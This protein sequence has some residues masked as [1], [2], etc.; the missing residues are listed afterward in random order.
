MNIIRNIYITTLLIL[1]SCLSV[2]EPSTAAPADKLH[3]ILILHS[4]HKGLGWTDGITEGIETTLRKSGLDYELFYEFLDS[5]RIAD[6][7]HSANL[8][9]T[10]RHKYAGRRFAAII[11]SDDFAFNFILRYREELFPG[12]PVVFCGVNFFEDGML[13]GHP[14]ITG[15][16]ESFSL[17]GTID[18]AL[19]INP[20]IRKIVAIDDNTITGLANRKLLNALIPQ[21]KNRLQF[22]FIGWQTM[23]EIQK[24]C[25]HLPDEAIVLLLSFTQDSAGEIFS[26][27]RSADLITPHCSVPVF[28]FWDFH[29]HHGVIGG[30]LTTGLSQGEKAAELALRILRGEAASDIPVVKESP[31]KYIFDYTVM[32]KFAID[33]DRLPADSMVINK[34][35]SLY[36]QYKVFFWQIFGAFIFLITVICLIS[37]NLIRRRRA[38]KALRRSEE[39]LRTIFQAAKTVA[40]VITDARLPEPT[41]IEFS[42]GAETIFG[43]SRGEVIGRPVTILHQAEDVATFPQGHKQMVE[44]RQ[45]L[46][47]QATLVRKNGE[48]F[49]AL[50]SSHPLFDEH[51]IMRAA[52]GV[53]IDITEQKKTEAALRESIERFRELSELLPETIFEIDFTGKILFLNNSGMEQFSFTAE[54]MAAGINAYDFFPGNEKDKLRRNLARLLSGEQIGLSEY[55]VCDKSGITFPVMTSSMVIYREG[56]PVGLRGFLIDIREKKQ[57]EENLRNA[58]RMES[59]GTLAGGIAHDFNNIL[60]GIQGRTSLSLMQLTDTSPLKEHLTCIEDYVK[61]AA[62]LTS[63]LLGFARSG[64]YHLESTDINDMA[65]KTL[66]MFGRTRKELTL[67]Q[68][69]QTDLPAAQVDRNQIEQVLLNLFVNAWQAMPKGGRLEVATHACEIDEAQ[70]RLLSL[71]PGRYVQLIVTDSGTG[72]DAAIQQKIFE[73]FFTTKTR[74]RGTGLG[75]ASAYGIVRNHHGTIVVESKVGEGATFT[76]Y[77]PATEARPEKT[78]ESTE[79]ISKGNETIL[80]IDDEPMV[81]QVASAILDHLG[82]TV[83]TVSS[84]QEAV[85]WYQEH[86]TTIDLIVLDM[87]MPEMSGEETFSRL[88]AI[89]PQVKVLLSSG[90]S[91]EGQA[92]KILAHG[93]SGFIQK[94]FDLLQ[95]SRKIREVLDS[96]ADS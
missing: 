96:G 22:E 14:L 63:Q 51:G 71:A 73:P 21:Y 31:N 5:K 58:Q 70:G 54:D 57:L 48:T 80:L 9:E 7:K 33:E 89:N 47:R 67:I 86:G 18:G 42:P 72:I 20:A 23:G 64:K 24:R 17:K 74:G 91:L 92:E 61:S 78:V 2:P 6:D 13:E 59:I 28:S 68:N 16:V 26:L 75:L 55:L 50:F 34:P 83:H 8:A 39:R 32:Q 82:Y 90:Y 40:F 15:V 69:L 87:I 53:S 3:N 45:G 38:E 81:I 12:I 25:S 49:P 44:S 27:E 10:F 46:S 36:A 65:E 35:V 37:V 4:Y 84:G 29:L 41:I 94:P 11:I 43:Y 56:K 88:Q 60:M 79:E 66:N 76:I 1:L 52:L 95:F 30:K 62:N 19:H 85:Q 77:L 93:C